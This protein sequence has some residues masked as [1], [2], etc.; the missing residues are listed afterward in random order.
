MLGQYFDASTTIIQ[1]LTDWKVKCNSA[2]TEAIL[3]TKSPKMLKLRSDNKIVLGKETLKWKD[4]V[5]YLGAILL[6]VTMMT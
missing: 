3:F 2:K 5:K 6:N 4:F 1:F